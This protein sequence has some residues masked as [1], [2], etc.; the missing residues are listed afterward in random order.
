MLTSED[1]KKITDAQI[2]AQKEVFYTKEDLDT[3][4]SNLQTSVDAIAL[5]Q[6]NETAKNKVFEHRLKNT[7]L[8]IEKAAPAV[9]LK[10]EQ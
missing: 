2:E 7:E 3:K 5:N 8:W 9:G 6:K 4:F 1:I 10:F